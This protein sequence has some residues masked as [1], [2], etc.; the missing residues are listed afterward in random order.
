MLFVLC[1]SSLWAASLASRSVLALGAAL[2]LALLALQL[3]QL[4]LQELFLYL[5]AAFRVPIPKH[6]PVRLCRRYT[7]CLWGSHHRCL[8]LRVPSLHPVPNS[9]RE[10]HVEDDSGSSSP[11]CSLLLSTPGRGSCLIWA[12]CYCSSLAAPDREEESS[13]PS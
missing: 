1:A 12:R 4:Q 10:G 7:G 6:P 13:A 2:P 8:A 11:S 3:L 9:R 5:Y